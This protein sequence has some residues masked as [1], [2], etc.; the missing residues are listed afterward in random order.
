MKK[1]LVLLSFSLLTACFMS[2][3]HAKPFDQDS[4][5]SVFKYRE[6]YLPEAIGTAADTLGLNNLDEDWGIWGHNLGNVLP[7][8][9][10]ETVFAKINNAT[11][12]KQFCF[13][14]NRLFEYIEEFIDNRYGKNDKA[15]FAIIPNDND[16]VCTCVRCVEAGNTS[17]DASPAVFNMVRRLA[18]RF[19]NHIFYTS[20][21]RTTRQLPKE[22]M[23][24]NTGVMVSAMPYPF[25]HTSTPEEE[26]F[27]NTISDWKEKTKRILIW[28]YINN[29]DDYFTPYPILGVMQNRLKNYRDNHV[30]AIFLNGSGH[31]ASS[32]SHLKSIV[33]AELT[34]DPETD[35]RTLLMDKAKE[36]YPVTG[37][38]VAQFILDQEDFIKDQQTSLPLYQGVREAIRTYL[39]QETFEQFFAK[40][41]KLR[42]FAVGKELQAV[43]TLL[44][45]LAMTQLELNRINGELEDS[46]DLLTLLETLGRTNI[47]SYN[48]AGWRIDS[49]IDDYQFLYDHYKEVG[50]SNKLKGA[51]LVALTPLDDDYTNL[52]LLSDGVLGM[53]SNYHNGHL[54]NTPE[55]ETSIAI[56]HVDGAKKLKVWLSYNPGYRIYLPEDVSLSGPGFDKITKTVQYPKDNSGHY[57]VEFDI[58]NSSTGSLIVS[59]HKAPETRSMAIE[60]IEEF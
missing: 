35:W 11:N 52:G 20:D 6:I 42:T 59:L 2:C 33:L 7:D 36:L 4:T 37:E 45:E 51:K 29:F 14:S 9:P 22:S 60:E 31:D 16:I 5:K 10:S 17:S 27:L 25:T 24:E 38:T 23:P 58:P 39:P 57:A 32:F 56:P 48:E 40:L 50:D 12:K 18:E 47:E 44:A 46:D 3:T 30:T 34:A 54:I 21:Y 53:P 49:Y 1:K 15:R 13:S 28:D 26:V 41:M 55:R 8:K 43:N 19:P